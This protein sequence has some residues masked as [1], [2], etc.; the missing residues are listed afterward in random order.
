MTAYRLMM[1]SGAVAM[2][3]L[4]A[5]G[6]GARQDADEQAGRYTVDVTQAAFPRRQRLAQQSLMRIAVKNAGDE[7]LP[8]VAVTVDSF[9]R[10]SEQ[11]GLADPERPIWI[12]DRGP[13]GGTTAYTNTWA[14]DGLAPGETRTFRWMVTAV[15]AGSYRVKYT[16][17]AGLDGK[18]KART[19]DG[20]SPV[21][22]T[23]P[24][25]I[26]QVPRLSRVDPRTGAVERVGR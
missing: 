21:T 18:A 6:G 15:E 1:S 24:V 9:S 5:C 19:T 20:E 13:R 25:R 4:S 8:D 12:V 17:A 23:F 3:A 11:P 10:R 7:A 22:G 26:S 16:V 2:L 14:L